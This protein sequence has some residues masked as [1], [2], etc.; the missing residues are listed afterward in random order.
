MQ[1]LVDFLK[2]EDALKQSEEKSR[3]YHSLCD[4]RLHLNC[5]LV[6]ASC[7]SRCWHENGQLY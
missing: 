3:E 2:G 1:A 7:F 6:V 5:Q 4:Q